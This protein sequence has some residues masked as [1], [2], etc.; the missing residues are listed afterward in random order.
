LCPSKLHENFLSEITPGRNNTIQG[1]ENSDAQYVPSE[2]KP[3]TACR[4]GDGAVRLTKVENLPIY[5][6]TLPGIFD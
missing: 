6:V 3:D 2:F 4:P 1:M 5:P